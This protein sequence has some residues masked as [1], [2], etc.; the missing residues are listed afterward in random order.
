LGENAV[1]LV[2]REEHVS[3]GNRIGGARKGGKWKTFRAPA[4]A[5]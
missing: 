1:G 3:E 2:K 4:E 5:C